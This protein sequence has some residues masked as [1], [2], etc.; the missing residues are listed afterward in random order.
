MKLI[1]EINTLKFIISVVST[2]LGDFLKL[3]TYLSDQDNSK[4]YFS[5]SASG[6][7]VRYRIDTD[8]KSWKE[9]YKKLAETRGMTIERFIA[10]CR[11]Y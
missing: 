4:F 9:V 3:E 2:N 8:S 1:E 5:Q 10:E 7:L 11:K 6:K